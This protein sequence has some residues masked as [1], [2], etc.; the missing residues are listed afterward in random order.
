MPGLAARHLSVLSVYDRVY[1]ATGQTDLRKSVD[2]L[3]V[4]AKCLSQQRHSDSSSY[5]VFWRTV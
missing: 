2:G 1:L 3:A 5:A 4:A